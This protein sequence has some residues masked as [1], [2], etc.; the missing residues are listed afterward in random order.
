MPSDDGK[1]DRYLRFRDVKRL[2]GNAWSDSR[3]RRRIEEGKIPSKK[4][5]ERLL[6]P[7]VATELAIAALKKEDEGEELD[8]GARD[9]MAVKLLADGK[10]EGE[11]VMELAMP[12]ERVARLRRALAGATEPAA[13][14]P[15][16]SSS[17][18]RSAPTVAKTTD[19][20]YDRQ[21]RDSRRRL[22]AMK[23]GT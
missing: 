19:D 1:N 4:E 7:R 22:A 14:A 23:K 15:R 10:T 12:I 8:A 13:D 16:P 18:I 3:I 9:A 11:V 20:F 6:F 21:I 2:L 17:T 5:G